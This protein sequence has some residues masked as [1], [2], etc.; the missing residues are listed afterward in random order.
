MK[1]M[2]KPKPNTLTSQALQPN[3]ALALRIEPLQKK[4]WLR[5]VLV[6]GLTDDTEDIER[7]AQFIAPLQNIEKIE[8]LPFHNL[9]PHKWE[10]LKLN[11]T[12][13]NQ[14]AP[15]EK[16]VQEVQDYLENYKKK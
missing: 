2:N 10:E 16:Q 8:V 13:K 4:V 6:P 5:Y 15:T 7:P 1:I 9:G 12:L 11:Y 14:K 3:F